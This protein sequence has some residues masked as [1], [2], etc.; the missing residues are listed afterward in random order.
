MKKVLR[1]LLLSILAIAPAELS[2]SGPVLTE[3]GPGI[4]AFIGEGGATN[5]GAV[6]TEAGV[7]V[8]D[9]QG[10]KE[11]AREF[12]R[13]I[14]QVT[15]SPVIFAINTHYHG[16]HTFGNQ[17][18]A[19]TLAIIAHE[20]TRKAL[21]ERDTAHRA[22]FKSFFGE[23]SL[24]GFVLTPPGATFA[25]ELTLWVGGRT[26]IIT[27][28]APA[29]TDGDAYVYMPAFKVVFTGDLLYKG[30]IPWL[31]DGDSGGAIRALDELLALDA[32]VYI[33]GHGPVAY[34]ED[35]LAYRGY[36]A[37]LRGEV[38]RLKVAGKTLDE[39]KS[40]IRLPKYDGLIMYDKWL[41]LNAAKVYEELG[42]SP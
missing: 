24:D 25:S 42:E 1:L 33:P 2:A 12:R 7:V 15:D 19:E 16:D 17:Y 22:R 18:F 10:P 32:E 6:V 31:G 29:H 37:D 23:E 4:Y 20:N 28:P 27:H 9:T 11:L 8:I 21:I 38:R 30:R 35:L 40:E 5:S 14:N 34:R 39:V 41:P 13:G 3:V 36:L 26:F